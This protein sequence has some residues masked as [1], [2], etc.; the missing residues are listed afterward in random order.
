MRPWNTPTSPRKLQRQWSQRIIRSTLATSMSWQQNAINELKVKVR[1]QPLQP[2]SHSSSVR[3]PQHQLPTH[4][5]QQL[6]QLTH[7]IRSSHVQQLAAMPPTTCVVTSNVSA[8]TSLQPP[9]LHLPPQQRSHVD[10][11][12][13]TPMLQLHA[14]PS[15]PKQ[16]S[17]LQLRIQLTLPTSSSRIDISIHRLSKDLQST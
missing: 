3:L 6:L 17:N 5:N 13:R 2:R 10:R 14:L 9:P 16:P 7:S 4:L 12:L 15:K 8:L 1:R 11:L